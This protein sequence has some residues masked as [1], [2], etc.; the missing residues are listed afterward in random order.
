MKAIKKISIFLFAFFLF[1]FLFAQNQ[2]KLDSL[3]I[4]FKLI[5]DITVKDSFL[6]LIE[7]ELNK[8]ETNEALQHYWLLIDYCKY[9]KYDKATGYCYYY[10]ARRL[11]NEGEYFESYKLYQES[12][13]YFE[14]IND[15]QGLARVY[16]GLGILF[17][18]INKFE[19]SLNHYIASAKLFME[20]NKPLSEGLIYQNIGS[21]YIERDSTLQAKSYLEK[22]IKILEQLNDTRLLNCYINLGEV[23]NAEKKYETSLRYFKQGYILSNDYGDA[24]D[25]FQAPY[26]LGR[27]Y[28]EQSNIHEAE[29]LLMEALM[30][31]KNQSNKNTI[32]I[33]DRSEFTFFMSI[34]YAK[35]GDSA[36][37]YIFLNQYTE[38]DAESK[39]QQSRLEYSRLQFDQKENEAEQKQ[40]RREIIIAITLIGLLFSLLLLFFV[41]NS[42]KNKQKA[43]RLLTE[44][45]E[46]KTRLY[47]DITHEL[48]T[49]LTLILGPLEQFLSS[50]TRKKFTRKQVKMMRKNANTLLNMINQILDLSKIEA[51]NIKLELVEED[52]NKFL[53]IRFAAF[54]SLAEQK[55][56]TYKYS[57]LKEKS[58]KVF[59]AAKLEKIINNL[60][61]NAI[62]FTPKNGEI[63]C[64]V[65][66]PQQNIIELIIR[67]SGKGM[68]KNELDIIFNRFHQVKNSETINTIGTGIGLSLTKELVELMH[69]KIEVES[70]L[71]KGSKFIVTLTLGTEHLHKEEF[72]L[73]ENYKSNISE[74]FEVS[75]NFDDSEDCPNYQDSEKAN[76]NL[77]HVLVTEDHDD[78]REFIAENLKE[79]FNMEQAENGKIGFNKATKNIPDL[80]ITDVVM[81]ETD[82][83]EFCRKLKTDERTSHI[84]VIMLTGKS[85]IDDKIKGLETGADAYLNKPFNIKELKIRVQKLIEQRQKLRE[86]FINNLN[87]EPKD[88]AVTSADEKFINK[89]MEIIESN[90]GNA[91][92]EVRQFQE[93]MFMSRMQL[94][95]KIKALTNQTPSEFIR[96]IRLKRAAS[97]MRQNFGNIAQITF[98]VGF[99]NPSYFA[100]C[101]KEL[102]GKLPSEYIKNHD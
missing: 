74:S 84:P 92:F 5:E 12:K 75:A 22:S 17:K 50:E 37:A 65:S 66:F 2:D 9:H 31:L 29:P 70:E 34:F 43:N 102:F 39:Q 47:S 38:Y 89:A 44:M 81:P 94:F 7:S 8:F 78:I 58:I 100:K 67:D 24:D 36:K 14:K 10:M 6:T 87:L 99:N 3:I 62:K 13:K 61:S 41:Y 71:G 98:E 23:Y 85:S 83:I 46:L 54:A 73:I 49:P 1:N 30:V 33:T 64:F 16:N 90:I 19:E 51:K 77:P 93:E 35:K 45:D 20:I 21:M 69:G 86:R 15:K 79:C 101:F 95:R 97:L 91:E 57:L 82:G 96:A 28:Y 68:P 26:H 72:H 63:S 52:I 48:R 76:N 40:K 88:I 18:D 60:I 55:Y 53:R 11:N 42:F 27:F 32:P 56:I 59:D 25:K 80:I 4:Q